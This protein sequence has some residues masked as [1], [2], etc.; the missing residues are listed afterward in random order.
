MTPTG[1]LTASGRGVLVASV[2]AL[3]GA[4]LL[5]A[6][7]V[8]AFG[9]AGLVLLAAAGVVVV[10]RPTVTVER[11]LDPARVTAGELAEGLLT[12]TNVGER[13]TPGMSCRE[14]VGP[15]HVDV[16]VPRLRPGQAVTVPYRLPTA[17]RSVVSVGPLVLSRRDPFGLVH[18]QARQGD[19][20]TLWVHPRWHAVAPLARARQRDQEG[21]TEGAASG[22]RV[23]HALREYVV[24]DDLRR[25]HWKATA[26]RGTL[27]VREHVDP[28]RPDLTVVL[29]DRGGVLDGDAFELAV[30]VLASVVLASAGRGFPLALR[31]VAGGLPVLHGRVERLALL[32]TLAG[33][34]PGAGGADAAAAIAAGAS[35]GGGRHTIVLVTGAVPAEE[36]A[37]LAVAATRVDRLVVLAVVPPG[38]A[39]APGPAGVTI[40]PVHDADSFVAAWAVRR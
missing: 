19:R 2:L 11:R 20:T 18:L 34:Q 37:A 5:A 17:R 8:A 31:S 1:G 28:A 14:V 4:R 21:L 32:D 30:E 10:R 26:H 25:V 40:L 13:R 6:P 24:G 27:M 7:E 36:T 16:A 35:A 39:I 38:T 3:L 29:D 33:V 15:D 23:F 12:V 9:V 22:D